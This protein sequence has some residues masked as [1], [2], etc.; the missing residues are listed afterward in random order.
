VN[1]PVRLYTKK[2]V[3]YDYVERSATKRYTPYYSSSLYPNFLYVKGINTS[4]HP[5]AIPIYFYDGTDTGQKFLPN[6]HTRDYPWWYIETTSSDTVKCPDYYSRLTESRLGREAV[7][8][9]SHRKVTLTYSSGE[10]VHTHQPFS[11]FTRYV[12]QSWCTSDFPA[13]LLS[14]ANDLVSDE[15]D[16]WPY[17]D[18][19]KQYGRAVTYSDIK[20]RF[21]NP[22]GNEFAQAIGELLM[23]AADIRALTSSITKLRAFPRAVREFF[24]RFGSLKGS[25]ANAKG[26]AS[27]HLAYEFGFR[28]MGE[29]VARLIAFI[30]TVVSHLEQLENLNGEPRRAVFTGSSERTV[31]SVLPGD[32]DVKS[33]TGT[34]NRTTVVGGFTIPGLGINV[35]GA[36]SRLWKVYNQCRVVSQ[37]YGLNLSAR[38]FWNLIPLT[39][40]YD[41]V[42]PVAD[43]LES[44]EAGA[45]DSIFDL[46]YASGTTKIIS[47]TVYTHR[48]SGAT[49]TAFEEKFYRS[50]RS[51][52]F[53]SEKADFRLNPTDLSLGILFG[54]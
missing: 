13:E 44:L 2:E 32:I 28:Q 45:V 25:I 22:H 10:G 26:V 54:L 35:S 18:F 33:F 38:R 48:P 46:I 17:V 21:L 29:D 43:W 20:S 4:T 7:N 16:P 5:E 34:V 8:Y 24:R 15:A 50:P 6:T 3:E 19:S 51:V 30:P 40:L 14:I 42:I 1:S 39:F 41:R 52:G 36:V 9:C 27:V 31:S 47:N 37:Y 53:V 12:A 11:S 49:L 23:V